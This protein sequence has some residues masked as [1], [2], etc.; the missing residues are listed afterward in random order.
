M[1]RRSEITKRLK[2]VKLPTNDEERD[3]EKNALRKKI[4]QDLVNK[5][6]TIEEQNQYLLE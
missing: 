5:Y 6:L 2:S 1:V 3:N 4:G